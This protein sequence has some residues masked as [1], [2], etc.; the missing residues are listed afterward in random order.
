MERIKSVKTGDIIENINCLGDRK[1]YLVLDILQN[2]KSM[3]MFRGLEVDEDHNY[4]VAERT[5]W[6][7]ESYPTDQIVGHIDISKFIDA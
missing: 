1:I 2:S 4:R 6:G 5:I 3:I 7:H